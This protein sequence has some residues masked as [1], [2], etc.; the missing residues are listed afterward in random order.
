MSETPTLWGGRFE[1][2]P[3]ELF[4]EFSRSVQIDCR[5][6]DHDLIASRAW[7]TALERAG[8]ISAADAELIRDG[9]TRLRES[10][11]EEVVA[12]SS[13][14][15]VHS[16]IE[17]SLT[18]LIG[19][20]AR[21][22]H[23]GRS[24]N[25]QVMTAMRMWMRAACD[26]LTQD[27]VRLAS[28]LVD[29][30]ARSGQ[31]VLPAYTHM[32]RAQPVLFAHWCLAW[33]AGLERD[34]E[35]LADAR[36]RINVL[37]LGS[38]A[39]VGT[40]WPVDRERLAVDL[41]FSGAS[42]NSIDAVSDRDSCIELVTCCSQIMVRLS[43]LAEDLLLYSGPE[44]RFIQV[45]DEVTTGSSLLPHK[46]NLDSM[47]LVRGKAGRVCGHLQALLVMSKGVPTSYARDLQ[48]DK[49]AV[50]DACDQTRGCCAV[51]ALVVSGVRCNSQQMIE[52]AR[53]GYLEA[54]E[55]ADHLVQ[56]GTTFRDAH[57]QV[58]RLVR[59]AESTGVEL[60]DLSDDDVRA[61]APHVGSGW[62]SQLSV[63]R[64]V[65][66]RAVS[67]GTAPQQVAQEIAR[68]R[69]WLATAST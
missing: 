37:P 59:H 42:V 31:A 46:R 44:Y 48:E 63:E 4:A 57:E 51:T 49:Q 35:R 29:L 36:R 67:G 15:D 41:D 40:S 23:T 5:L 25:D 53:H 7:A 2:P 16:W 39:C 50:F 6:L 12:A 47:E 62:K 68:Y 20:S 22:L 32:Q 64:A 66:R 60:R 17:A 30:A 24:R 8:V 21:S 9:L 10:A 18:A 55:L 61:H 1:Q 34:I 69:G 38:G 11:S 3:H 54:M 19:E 45:A 58:G 33:V 56:R 43:R 65:A 52:A 28:A 14:E 27:L 26:E 13:A